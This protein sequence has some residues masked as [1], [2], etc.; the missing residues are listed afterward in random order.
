[1][2]DLPG[3]C[4][5]AKLENYTV[6]VLFLLREIIFQLFLHRYL[7]VQQ[8]FSGCGYT[9]FPFFREWRMVRLVIQLNLFKD[10]YVAILTCYGQF[11]CDVQR[12][13]NVYLIMSCL[14]DRNNFTIDSVDI[15]K[16]KLA[17]RSLTAR[18]VFEMERW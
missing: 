11:I 12:H 13:R 16:N 15:G 9:F 8:L 18:F 10:I 2:H 17:T 1:M 3:L 14:K 5:L 7:T 6:C 4:D